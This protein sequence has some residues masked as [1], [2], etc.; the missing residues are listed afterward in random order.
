LLHAL[1]IGLQRAGVA[2]LA[3]NGVATIE[4]R[5]DRFDVRTPQREFTCECIVLA[6]GLGNARLAP[7]VGLSAPLVPNK[8]QIIVLERVQ[9]FLAMP[10]ETI[11][12][13]DEGTVLLGDSQQERGFDEAADPAILAAIAARAVRVFPALR[14][15]RVVRTWAAL[16]VMSP[17]G[18]P[19]YEQSR[20]HPGAFLATCHS[21]VTLAAAHALHLAP[22]IRSGVL[23]AEYEP[24]AVERFDVRAVA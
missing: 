19:I 24:Y 16:R 5:A 15:V 20:A 6:A 11:R 1:H 9:P 4:P 3:R 18:F 8:G 14:E 2:R 23:G 17:D 7:M 13:T 10:L 21:G 12:Q 22:A